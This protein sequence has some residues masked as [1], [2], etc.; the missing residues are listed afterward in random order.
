MQLNKWM[1]KTNFGRVLNY[2]NFS[3][4]NYLIFVSMFLYVSCKNFSIY[5]LLKKIK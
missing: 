5:M 1:E 4:A 3:L 2:V